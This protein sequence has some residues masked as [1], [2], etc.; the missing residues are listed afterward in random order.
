[1]CPG[2]T[3]SQPGCFDSCGSL[4]VALSSSF[5]AS[6]AFLSVRSEAMLGDQARLEP[7]H[8]RL[9]QVER[10]AEARTA[11]L[12]TG[13]ATLVCSMSVDLRVLRCL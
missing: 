13:Y 1:M 6:S 9:G 4:N 12:I 2:M 10:Q 8:T 3:P 5:G 7:L 11:K